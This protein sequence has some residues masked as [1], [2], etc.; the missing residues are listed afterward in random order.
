MEASLGNR[1][2]HACGRVSQR[3]AGGVS[4]RRCGRAGERSVPFFGIGDLRR[5]HTRDCAGD[6]RRLRRAVVGQACR[7][8]NGQRSLV[9][10]Q[11]T[12]CRGAIRR[13]GH[14]G[15][16]V[17]ET[18]GVS[19]SFCNCQLS[20]NVVHQVVCRHIHVGTVQ[21]L[22]RTGRNC[23]RVGNG[24]CIP[25][26]CDLR[27]A[28]PTDKG[29]AGNLHL[30]RCGNHRSPN[31]YSLV[32][33]SNCNNTGCDRPILRLRLNQ[34]IIAFVCSFNP[35]VGE[36]NCLVYAYICIF[37]SCVP[38]VYIS[39]YVVTAD[40]TFQTRSNG[41]RRLGR[42]VIHLV[43]CRDVSKGDGLLRDLIRYRRCRFSERDAG[44]I[45][46]GIA[47]R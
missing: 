38:C 45:I 44:G 15:P 1:V 34:F 4:A 11:R 20:R 18:V 5:G 21:N 31:R 22:N 42:A 35:P 29:T 40:C 36:C 14:A 47:G 41:A 25:C 37:K 32:F 8:V 27:Y 6:G 43:L 12:I 24:R 13:D 39:V 33:C 28:V 19:R 2:I 16:S 10:G 7:S 23:T 3:D 17:D 26:Q 9:V 30:V 46:P